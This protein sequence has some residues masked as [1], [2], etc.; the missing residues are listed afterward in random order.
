MPIMD[1]CEASSRIRLHLE[2]FKI[3]QPMIVAITGHSEHVYVQKALD[4]GMNQVL[5]KPVQ[6][7]LLNSIFDELDFEIE[8]NP[9]F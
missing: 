3:R 9:K 4:S 6:V 5:I 8:T 2:E 7:N 1:G